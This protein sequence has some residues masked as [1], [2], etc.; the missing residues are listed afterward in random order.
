MVGKGSFGFQ[1][2]VSVHHKGKS[3]Q[4]QKQ[5]DGGPLAAGCLTDSSSLANILSQLKTIFP[6]VCFPQRGLLNH[7][8]IKAIPIDIHIGQSDLENA[9]N[10]IPLS[11]DSRMHCVES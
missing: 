10:G 5:N 8:T 3:D 9:S 2:L 11:N 7:I 1:F 4:E 6:G